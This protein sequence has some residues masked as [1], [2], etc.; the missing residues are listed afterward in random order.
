MRIRFTQDVEVDLAAIPTSAWGRVQ[1]RVT[2]TMPSVEEG[3]GIPKSGPL[4]KYLPAGAVVELPA[5]MA[6]GYIAA[7]VAESYLGANGERVP[8]DSGETIE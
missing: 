1:R 2:M 6:A 3:F 8:D 5:E 7:D 4:V